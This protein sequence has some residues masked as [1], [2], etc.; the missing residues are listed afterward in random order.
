MWTQRAQHKKSRARTHRSRNPHKNL[1][2][3]YIVDIQTRFCYN[4]HIQI[5]SS[6]CMITN[7]HI[8]SKRHM[9][10]NQIQKRNTPETNQIQSSSHMHIT[11][12]TSRYAYIQI[13]ASRYTCT[14]VHAHASRSTYMCDSHNIG[15]YNT[16]NRKLLYISIMPTDIVRKSTHLV[17]LKELAHKG[18]FSIT[19]LI[20]NNPLCASSFSGT[21]RVDFLTIRVGTIEIYK[22]FRFAVL[23]VPIL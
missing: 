22:S 10:L 18:L 5:Q 23:Y 15:T 4:K 14:I 6:S 8:I 19:N 17:P 21:R 9:T 11:H 13:D 3:I 7:T 16:A 12:N 20:E 2:E 1:V